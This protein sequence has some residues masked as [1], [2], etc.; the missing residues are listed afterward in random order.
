MQKR[1]WHKLIYIILISL[2]NNLAPSF[3]QKN[4]GQNSKNYQE[5]AKGYNFMTSEKSKL[6][7]KAVPM[8]AT[9]DDTD[10][11]KLEQEVAYYQEMVRI[12]EMEKRRLVEKKKTM[13]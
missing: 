9:S 4:S 5:G 6:S 11:S 10:L 2:E 8:R 12:K 7:T 1:D 3:D 13:E